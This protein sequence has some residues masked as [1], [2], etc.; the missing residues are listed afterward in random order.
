FSDVHERLL[1]DA[2]DLMACLRR[3][4]RC[5]GVRNKSCFDAGF[6]AELRDEVFKERNQLAKGER[7]RLH[8]LHQ[9]AGLMALFTKQPLNPFELVAIRRPLCIVKKESLDLEFQSDQR[10]DNTVM[11]LSRGTN[12][13]D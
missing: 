3:Q 6:V 11:Y 13:L 10:L 7:R 9:I 1:N 4:R 8:T 12:L 5:L 2:R